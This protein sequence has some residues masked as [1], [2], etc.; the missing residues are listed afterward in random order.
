MKVSQRVFFWMMGIAVMIL[1]VTFGAIYRQGGVTLEKVQ[2]AQVEQAKIATS[3]ENH[4]D[5]TELLKE[6]VIE[7]KRANGHE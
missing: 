5:N 2:A 4:T 1:L 6:I 7:M 3:L